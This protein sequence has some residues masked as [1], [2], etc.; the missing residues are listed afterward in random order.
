MEDIKEKKEGW[1]K[2]T[3]ELIEIAREVVQ[4]ARKIREEKLVPV[5]PLTPYEESAKINPYIS[6]HEIISYH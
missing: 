4:V 2:E 3:A 5:K 6:D 1:S